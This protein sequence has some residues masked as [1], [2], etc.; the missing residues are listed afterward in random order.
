MDAVCS[1]SLLTHYIVIP[2]AFVHKCFR[3]FCETVPILRGN[4]ALNII[5][6]IKAAFIALHH[7]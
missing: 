2:P 3:C 5:R 7:D 1:H 4:R 6:D